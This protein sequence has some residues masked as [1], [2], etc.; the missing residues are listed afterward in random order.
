EAQ[1]IFSRK[2]GYTDSSLDDIDN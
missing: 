1:Q 2:K